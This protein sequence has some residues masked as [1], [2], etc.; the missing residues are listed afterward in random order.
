MILIRKE[1]WSYDLEGYVIKEFEMHLKP[2]EML[3][4]T[5]ALR[6]IRQSEDV[7]P[8]DMESADEMVKKIEERLKE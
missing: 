1:A 2:A 7:H 3:I 5:D 6:M 8:R 4:V